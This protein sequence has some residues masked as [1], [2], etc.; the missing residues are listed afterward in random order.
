KDLAD[1]PEHAAN[2]IVDAANLEHADPTLIAVTMKHES[3]FGHNLK[4]NPRYENGKFTGYHDVGWMQI[5]NDPAIW[6][7][8][9]YTDGLPNAYGSI[10]AGQLLDFNG[11]ELQNVRLG[12]RALID[13]T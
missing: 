2:L 6:N 4:P 7:K 8:S 11:D 13:S 3:T 12:A 10:L 9:P 1:I 5:A